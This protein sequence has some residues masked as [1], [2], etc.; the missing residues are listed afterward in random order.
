M[1]VCPSVYSCVCGGC[2]CVCVVL[3]G[4]SVFQRLGPSA[5]TAVKLLDSECA[6]LN[7]ALIRNTPSLKPAEGL[8]EHLGTV[9]QP[10]GDT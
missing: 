2:E 6:D 9:A 7:V 3:L 8:T 4:R 10:Y 5:D 1:S